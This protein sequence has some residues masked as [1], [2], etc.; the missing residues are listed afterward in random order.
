MIRKY[1]VRMVVL[2]LIL[3]LT[4]A[5]S[6]QDGAVAAGLNNPRQLTFDTDGTL[7]IAEAGSGGDRDVEGTFG[8]AKAGE[9]AQISIVSAS[10]EQS[11]LIDNLVSMDVGFGQIEGVMALHV[12]E[13]SYWVVFGMGPKELQD[14]QYA[15]ALV[16]YDRETLEV[17]QVVDLAA[18][19]TENN[20]DQA[21]EL[22]SNPSDIAVDANGTVYIADASANAVLTWTAEDGVQVF[23]AWPLVDGE[24][25]AVPTSVSVGPDGD[26]YVGFLSGFPFPAQGARIERYSAEGELKE[27]YTGLTLV[28]DILVT[29]DGML[30]A[31]EFAGGFGDQG[32]IPASGRVVMVSSDGIEVVAEGLN[33]PYAIAQNADG[34]LFVSVESYGVPADS[35]QVIMVGGM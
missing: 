20:P 25:A 29:A 10:G 11:V 34:Q 7:Y 21:D 23:A 1:I 6:A 2:A 35:G 19:E 3:G 30:Y 26:I 13:D 16:Q 14:G 24:L 5:A 22:V 12:T 17:E 28:T 18:F 8:P 9:T 31:V 27:T 33:F 4:A 32:Y 15:S